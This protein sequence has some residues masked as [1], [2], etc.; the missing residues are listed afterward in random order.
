MLI[1]ETKIIEVTET[2]IKY[3]QII[4]K[5]IFYVK[6]HTHESKGF[7]RIIYTYMYSDC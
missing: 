7:G 4:E 6:L 2:A 1:P 3:L 5:C